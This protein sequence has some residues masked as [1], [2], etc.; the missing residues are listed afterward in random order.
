[1]N[2]GFKLSIVDYCGGCAN[3]AGIPHI[4]KSSPVPLYHQLRMVLEYQIREG[5][6]KP[7][8][9]VLGEND[10]C[11]RYDVSRTTVRQTIREMMRDGILYREQKRGRPIVVPVVVRQS[12]MKLQG[13]F[14]EGMLTA[15]LKPSTKVISVQK[16][17]FPE[18]ALKMNLAAKAI[19]YRIE[20]IHYGDEL[21]LALQVSYV[22]KSICPML[23]EKSLEGSLFAYI[24]YDYGRPIV[25]AKQII[26]V[27]QSDNRVRDLL[28]MSH[29]LPMY[30]VERISFADD[31]QP[32]EYFECLLRGDRYEFEMELDWQ[33]LG[34][35]LGVE[36]M[37][38]QIR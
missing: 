1:M 2:T 37:L 29:R 32:V 20:R 34:R 38:G 36:P 3:L 19:L 31:G 23:H 16:Q 13:F 11:E 15:K 22:P 30:K 25:K 7:G 12:L 35:E 26:G 28:Q 10:L 21:P 5:I 24:E 4:D 17:E 8:E 14:T 18:V 6:Y 27:R 9:P 33:I